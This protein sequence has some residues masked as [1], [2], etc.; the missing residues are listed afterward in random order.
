MK[1]TVIEKS[2][3]Y[4]Q[5]VER[6]CNFVELDVRSSADGQ[7]VLLHDQGLQRL[8]ASSI[9]DIHSVEWEKIKDIDIG[10]NHPNR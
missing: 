2:V 9:S 7:L 1:F 3:L 5:C 4:F 8:A 10:A 6:D